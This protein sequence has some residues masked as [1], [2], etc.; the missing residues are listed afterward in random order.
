[1]LNRK[2]MSAIVSVLTTPIIYLT[3]FSAIAATKTGTQIFMCADDIARI[4][5]ETN[6]VDDEDKNISAPIKWTLT[7]ADPNFEAFYGR[8]PEDFK[9]YASRVTNTM[10]FLNLQAE[11][12]NV[13]I[14]IDKHSDTGMEREEISNTAYR[15]NWNQPLHKVIMSCSVMSRKNVAIALKNRAKRSESGL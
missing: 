7:F 1:M 15:I 6:G 8:R 12:S 4:I 14:S 9:L 3:S 2:F 10:I 13:I 11:P 5:I